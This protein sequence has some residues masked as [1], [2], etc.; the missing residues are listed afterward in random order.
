MDHCS[1]LCLIKN[2]AQRFSRACNHFP[3]LHLPVRDDIPALALGRSE[4]E[5]GTARLRVIQRNLS[6]S[7]RHASDAMP[8][9]EVLT[10][11]RR[12]DHGCRQKG[13]A[14]Q[15]RGNASLATK[16]DR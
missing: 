11:R 13:S 12:W 14:N 2:A 6:P 15:C 8:G 10:K 1:H 9:G 7:P 4:F 16:I 3:F 5:N